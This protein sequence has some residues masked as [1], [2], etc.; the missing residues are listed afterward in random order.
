MLE[1][2]VSLYV[3]VSLFSPFLLI[4]IT[5]WSMTPYF[6]NVIFISPSVAKLSSWLLITS[7]LEF[8]LSCGKPY[9]Y[10]YK[11]FPFLEGCQ[12]VS[13]QLLLPRFLFLFFLT[14]L[15]F[16]LLL[17]TF[18]I[19]KGDNLFSGV[20]AI[21]S[22]KMNFGNSLNSV[23]ESD[24]ERFLF[25]FFVLRKAIFRVYHSLD[26]CSTTHPEVQLELGISQAKKPIR[27]GWDRDTLPVYS[28]QEWNSE[29]QPISSFN[30]IQFN[31]GQNFFCFH[32]IDPNPSP[33]N[34]YKIKGLGIVPQVQI[35]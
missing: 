27:P 1:L 2:K 35:E 28:Y 30:A 22:S 4:L 3:L 8:N 17:M 19:R 13:F 21:D 33:S 18:S 26:L 11:I 7:L 9:I 20:S 25:A 12:H 29:P 5:L 15:R 31:S 23:S 34:T 32:T 6:C 24:S 16:S 10:S 14:D